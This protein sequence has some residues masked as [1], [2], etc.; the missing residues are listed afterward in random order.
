[1][2]IEQ[3]LLETLEVGTQRAGEI[4]ISD[5]TAFQNRLSQAAALHMKAHSLFVQIRFRQQV[6]E[7]TEHHLIGELLAIQHRQA[8]RQRERMKVGSARERETN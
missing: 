7:P 2:H 1:M 8:G 4:V 6:I 3:R 5:E